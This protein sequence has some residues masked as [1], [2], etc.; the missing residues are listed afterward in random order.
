MKNFI[1]TFL[2]LRFF[3]S[4]FF[5]IIGLIPLTILSIWFILY[6]SGR[7]GDIPTEGWFTLHSAESLIVNT[8]LENFGTDFAYISGE[9]F[10]LLWKLN[11]S[12]LIASILASITWSAYSHSL[13]IDAPGKA[14]IY[15]IHWIIFTGIFIGILF[16]INYR[17]VNTEVYDVADFISM[18]GGFQIYI[19]TMVFYFVSYYAAVILGTARFARSSVLFANKLPGNL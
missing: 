3:R 14:K 18:G 6:L 2:Q 11:L 10:T 9:L 7:L 19:F 16:G 8:K 15:F 13:N 5:C 17:F 1:K 4:I 12:L